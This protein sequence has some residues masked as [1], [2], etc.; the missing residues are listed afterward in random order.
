MSKHLIKYG[1]ETDF[2][3]EQGAGNFVTS[4][5][6]GVAYVVETRKTHYNNPEQ[7]EQSNPE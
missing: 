5:T 7:E 1:L 4:I 6:P 3:N 2:E